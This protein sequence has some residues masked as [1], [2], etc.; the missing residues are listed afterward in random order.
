MA[1]MVLKEG[2]ALHLAAAEPEVIDPVDA[3]IDDAG[4]LWVVEMRDYPLRRDPA[5]PPRGRVRILIDSD[6]DG[7][8]DR[9]V[10]FA[11]Q[12]D[13]PTGLA[14]WKDGAVLTTGGRLVWFRDVNGDGQADE[15]QV[16][17]E[18]F[19]E[20]NEQLRANHPRL[21]WDG[22]WTIA[23]GLRGGKVRI[24]AGMPGSG[25]E[26]LEIGSRDVRY[27]PARG[28][29]EP[30]TGPAQFGLTRDEAGTRMFCSNRNP[31]VQVVFEQMHL[32]GNPLAG[33][34]PA[35]RDVLPAGE[36]S[37][38]YPLANAW[39]TSNLH[40]GQ[41]TAACG[42]LYRT[43]TAAE[44]ART[45]QQHPLPPPL[46]TL[47]HV[48]VCEPTGSLVH[49]RLVEHSG[50]LWQPLCP[51]ASQPQGK[52]P[53][54]APNPAAGASG[55]DSQSAS[56]GATT[57]ASTG[58]AREWLASHDEWFRPVNLVTAPAGGVLVID[59]HRAV[60][61]HPDWVPDEL[62]RRPDERF[63]EDAGRIYWVAP[64]SAETKAGWPRG[65]MAELAERPLRS[66]SSA[67]LATLVSSHDPWVRETASRVLVER[68]ASE[69]VE[70]LRA[71]L[72]DRESTSAA[73]RAAA[74]ELLA[75]FD[76]DPAGQ[77]LAALTDPDRV[78]QVVAL[79]QLSLVWMRSAPPESAVAS[80]NLDAAGKVIAAQRA[81]DE[82]RSPAGQQLASQ[83]RTV[84]ELAEA[85]A[86]PWVRL[87]AV[88]CGAVRFDSLDVME[89][90]LASEK[91]GRLA[92]HHPDDL[93]LLVAVGA[94]TRSHPDKMFTAWFDTLGQTD[95]PKGKL[96]LGSQPA[97]DQALAT[98][99]ALY[100][101]H[102]AKSHRVVMADLLALVRFHLNSVEPV[103]DSARLM[104]VVALGE[105]AKL[106]L[107]A[108]S[109]VQI[110]PALW[111][112]TKDLVR[113][114]KTAEPI[115]LAAVEVLGYSSQPA[116]RKF[117]HKRAIETENGPLRMALL[118]AWARQSSP[119]CDQYVVDQLALAGP[120][121]RPVLL[122]LTLAA[123]SRAG[124]LAQYL[125]E[126][127]LTA[128]QLGAVDLQ[129]CVDRSPAEL[130]PRFARQ[131]ETILNTDRAEV[132]RNY[133][134][135]LTLAGD[136]PRGKQV[137]VKHCAACHRIADVGTNVGPD[138][139]DSRVH[140]PEKLLVAILDPNRAIDNN[141]FRYVVLTQDGRTFDG[142]I[143]EETTDA[144][145]LRGQNDQRQVIPRAS[146]DQIK[147]TGVSLMPEGLESQIDPQAMA[148]LIAFI[149]NWRYE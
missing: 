66:R 133:Q 123:P 148:D 114:P 9:S 130:K 106:S 35:A 111:Q 120:S 13:M 63:G 25:G 149:K 76:P 37:R 78:V 36:A 137:F 81:A 70:P 2:Y 65:W 116:D 41:F 57:G 103:C 115:R 119:E 27:D 97:R 45:L 142:L 33:L 105:L 11:D 118:R 50:A 53:A 52:A 67:E 108:D 79:R 117:L 23:C 134:A 98:A 102:L 38:V 42:V 83:V 82:Q 62:K 60:I 15:Q 10:T 90:E 4:R 49:D 113:M 122:E 16:W 92:A 144:I 139:S 1:E 86:D 19:A 64:D 138:I 125:E 73:A 84:I 22:S 58:A 135:S 28:V 141:Y 69:V 7:L 146:I 39:T 145:V 6:L 127:K 129:R 136:L 18:G 43:L 89:A 100:I 46:A 68:E 147:A 54:T 44:R 91:L 3:V 5:Q 112:T 101:R 75:R 132:I 93:Q 94:L 17:L 88:L 32:A 140:Q 85:T 30:V 77:L 110:D 107:Q 55:G 104:A 24:A 40:A 12:L 26:P 74:L 8:Y 61:E 95:D 51:A 34:V 80:A 124:L 20:Q 126:G 121:L 31:C 29:L 99:T 21:A 48:L 72:R 96:C 109:P 14:L 128:K 71:V 59:M 143:A 87:E 47:G 131:L 56:Q